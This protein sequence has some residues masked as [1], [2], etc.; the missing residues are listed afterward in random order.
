MSLS[1]KEKQKI[2][3]EE[4]YR[5]KIRDQ[6]NYRAEIRTPVKPAKKGVGCGTAIVV[7][8]L[9]CV[10]FAV[11]SAIFEPRNNTASNPSPTASVSPVKEGTLLEKYKYFI[12]RSDDG[13]YAVT[14]V[15][16]L[17]QK[18][19]LLAMPIVLMDVY[20]KHIVNDGYQLVDRNGIKYFQFTGNDGKYLVLLVKEDTGETHSM[21]FWKE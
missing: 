12:G 6:E 1:D 20:G 3:E 16:F 15:P 9:V 21:V 11:L 8:L 19:V 4:E 18:D 17:P 7:F 5:Q 14:F 2:I 10:G 13:R